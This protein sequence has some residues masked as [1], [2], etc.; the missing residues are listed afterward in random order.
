MSQLFSLEQSEKTSDDYLTPRWVFDMLDLTFDLDVAAPPWETH[1]PAARKFTKADDGLSQIWEG[2]VWMNPPYSA[3]TAWVHRFIQHGNGIALLPWAKS[4]WTITI[5]SAADAIALPRRIFD[6]DGGSISY[7]VMFAAFG[8][9]S[10][11]AIKR[12]GPC[13][14]AGL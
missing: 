1:V 3:A 14:G 7:M 12:I 5:Y 8:A 2:R 10:I 11:E 13:R 9:D 4:A 6:F